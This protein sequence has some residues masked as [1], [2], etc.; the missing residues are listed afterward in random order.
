VIRYLS[1]LPSLEDVVFI[2]VLVLPGFVALTLLRWIAI[3]ESKLSDLILVIGSLLMS[4]MIY[5]FFGLVTGELNFSTIRDSMILPQNILLIFGTSVLFGLIPGIALKLIFRGGIVRGDS[6][7]VCMRQASKIG[8]WV[9]VYTEDGKEYL[10]TLHY[11]GGK[12]FAKEV[13]IRIP[14]Q[15]FRNESGFLVDQVEIGEEML[16]SAEN[17]SRIAF[18]DKV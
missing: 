2:I 7:E 13:S 17:I 11:S 6:W 16:F 15:I 10:G 3:F 12:G 5:G 4:I 1:V 18:F 9:I 14:T 8:T